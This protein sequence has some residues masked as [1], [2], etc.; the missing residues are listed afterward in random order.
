M[1]ILAKATKKE[2]KNISKRL[3]IPEGEVLERAF[4]YYSN[5]FKQSI[6]FKNE[7]DAWDALSDRSFLSVS[8][9]EIRDTL[10]IIRN[11]IF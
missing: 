6:D 5:S 11:L 7:L 8:K 1:Q 2:V 9:I 4:A 10:K 3:G